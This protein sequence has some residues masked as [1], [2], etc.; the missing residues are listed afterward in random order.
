[1]LTTLITVAIVALLFGLTIF[2]HEFGH[3]LA[4]RLCGLVIETFSIGFGPAIWKR[5]HNGIVYKIGCIPFGG[6]V[7]LPQLDPSGM[8]LVQ[9]S[10]DTQTTEDSATA[11]D[12]PFVAAPPLPAIAPWKRI[13][14]SLAGAAGNVL[15]AIVLAWA[16]YLIGKPAT[17][18]EE[19]AMVGYV[20][21]NS[22][23]YAGGLRIGDEV[24]TVNKRPVG[25]WM[26][27]LMACSMHETVQIEVRRGTELVLLTI[28][29]EKSLYEMDGKSLC[30]V[31]LA[32]P[33]LSA[34][35]AGLTSGDIIV[36]FDGRNIISRA[37][38]IALV[39]A[40]AGQTLPITFKRN[41]ELLTSMVTPALDQGS[42]Q[43][44]I[45]IQFNVTDVDFNHIVHPG[46][47]Q[48][49]RSHASAIF[50]TLS[51]LTTPGQAGVTSR[52]VGGPLA[53]LISYY[54]IVRASLMVAVFFTA[55]LNINL[56]IF[57]VL[58]I[59]ILDG[60]HVMFALWEAIFRRPVH[61]RVVVVITNI[62]AVLLIG[63]FVLLTGRDFLRFTPLG[64]YVNKWMESR[65][66]PAV[67]APVTP[68]VPAPAAATPE[69]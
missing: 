28:P 5:K 32:E 11:P 64:R 36:A 19:N 7:A 25:N 45:G 18:S 56:A 6:Y 41:G 2:V 58:P 27:F 65:H 66:P 68:G 15:L 8:S 30:M 13:V 38:L 10:P 4:A 34:D 33:G 31:L 42:G 14:V 53:I 54:Y 61:P 60:G 67:E 63:V 39:G 3:F 50:R 44:R 21:E 22:G 40:R 37:Q 62:F 20:A 52:Q 1:M 26:D 16:V 43:V 35:K 57:N 49:I 24:L 29:G 46:P 9:G 69:P 59:P 23:A 55:F 17:P 48:Q 12:T 51:A 47:W